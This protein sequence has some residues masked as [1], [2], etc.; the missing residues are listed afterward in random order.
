MHACSTHAHT[1][2]WML[3]YWS[4]GHR[5]PLG[6]LLLGDIVAQAAVVLQHFEVLLGR[7]AVASSPQ[8]CVVHVFL[9]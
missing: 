4:A 2:R 5:Q 3:L 7:I 6:T 1:Y 8:P 9:R